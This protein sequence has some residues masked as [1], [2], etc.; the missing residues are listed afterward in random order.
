MPANPELL[1]EFTEADWDLI[2]ES[3]IA[4]SA[5]LARAHA[6]AL[7]ATLEDV[8]R[9]AIFD[10]LPVETPMGASNAMVAR[11]PVQ[12]GEEMTAEDLTWM[13]SHG[14]ATEEPAEEAAHPNAPQQIFFPWDR[15]IRRYPPRDD[16]LRKLRLHSSMG[17]LPK[18]E[19]AR[20]ADA[21]IVF[22]GLGA[23]PAF[24]EGLVAGGVASVLCIV[25][26]SVIGDDGDADYGPAQDVRGAPRS[27]LLARKL[28]R[29]NPYADIDII[30][31]QVTAELGFAVLKD[32]PVALAVD[33]LSEMGDRAAL[34]EAVRQAQTPLL[35]IGE[36]SGHLVGAVERFDLGSEGGPALQP[37]GQRLT[38]SGAA[39]TM[40]CL[41]DVVLGRRKDDFRVILTS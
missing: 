20:L 1:G 5:R 16:L 24:A 6:V 14:L 19:A 21:R 15:T 41:L 30:Q 8:H 34:R 27:V 26:G 7:Q 38:G 25:D 29:V 10:A 23:G 32:G 22:A 36:E 35:T 2:A 18:R 13:L 17:P 11:R 4:A 40:S 3:R 12:S 37:V 31:R 9:F 39:R 33:A 28:W